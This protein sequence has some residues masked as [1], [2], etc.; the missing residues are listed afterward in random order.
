MRFKVRLGKSRWYSKECN[1]VSEEKDGR[2]YDTL[3]AA[4]M[5]NLRA[6]PLNKHTHTIKVVSK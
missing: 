4:D 3:N 2:V 6:F 5:D 1:T